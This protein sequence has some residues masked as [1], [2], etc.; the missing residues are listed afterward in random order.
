M[1][2]LHLSTTNVLGC[3]HVTFWSYPLGITSGAI[4]GSACS[5]GVAGSSCH[6]LKASRGKLWDPH[7][8]IYNTLALPQH[9]M[10]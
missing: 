4:R 2:T 1:L 9:T 7:L 8:L 5:M 3:S 10:S 6:S